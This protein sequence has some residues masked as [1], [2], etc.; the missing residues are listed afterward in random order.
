MSIDFSTGL[1]RIVHGLRGQNRTLQDYIVFVGLNPNI[2]TLT[3]RC[4]T[5]WSI[6]KYIALKMTTNYYKGLE[7]T[8]QDYTGFNRT[9]KDYAEISKL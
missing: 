4:K 6:Q 1:Y 9:I 2:Q 3:R 5:V 8:I 7:W